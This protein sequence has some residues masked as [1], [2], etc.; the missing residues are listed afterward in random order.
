M[1]QFLTRAFV[2]A[3]AAMSAGLALAQGAPNVIDNNPVLPKGIVKVCKVGGPGIP[4]GTPFTFT[5]GSNTFTVPTGPTPGGTCVVGPS[6]PVGTHVTVAET[7]P[8][9]Y[10]VSSITV[11]PQVRQ[12]GTPNL[13]G[14]SV[15]VTVGSGV[16]EVT[17]TDKR[18][19]F[20][21]ICKNGDVQGNFNF[22][23]N[24]GGLGP[25]VVPA[26]AC[27]PAIEVAAGVVTIHELPT[28]GTGMSGCSTIPPGQQGACNLGAQTSTVTV[29]P[30]DV[31]T[32]T[33]AFVTNKKVADAVD[34]SLDKKFDKGPTVGTGAFTLTVKNEGLPIG[35]GTTIPAPTIKITDSVPAG[36]TFTGFGGTSGASWSCTPTFSVIGPNT[37]TCT[38]TGT[39]TIATGAVLPD[40]VFNATL[41]P[42]GS[43]IGIYRNCATVALLTAAGPVTESNTAN[44]Q[45]C[46]VNERINPIPCELVGN[47]PQPVAVCRQ[48]VLMVVD[49]SLSITPPGLNTVKTAIGKFLQPMQGKGGN[50][51][52]VSF[53]NAGIGT[54][55]S[56]LTQITTGGWVPVA[57]NWSTLAAPIVLGGTRTDWDDAL[58]RASALLAAP[59]TLPPLVLFITDG[60]PTAYIDNTSGLEIDATNTPV[61]AATEA[62]QWINAIRA[63]GSGSPI[64]A[65]G[66]GPVAPLG[67]L[68]AAFTGN[69]SGPGNINFE[70]SSV[71]KMG[72]VNDL[73]GVMATLGNQMC[74][75]LSLN[76]RVT[77]GPQFV[78]V[79][80]TGAT[81]LQVND[82]V[83]FR[84]ELTNNSS[85]T[86]VA[87]I[88][89]QDQV[90]SF[91]NPPAMVTAFSAGT[92]APPPTGNLIIWSIPM[93]AAR[94]TVTLDFTGKFVKTYP[95]PA[96]N[97]PTIETYPNYAQV[98]AAPPSYSAT[99]VGNMDPLNGPVTEVDES[100][101]TFS[102]YVYVDP[103][104][105]AGKPT[106]CYVQV[107]K[108][109]KNPESCTPSTGGTCQYTVNVILNSTNIPAGSTVT[110][111]DTFMVGTTPVSTPWP[112]SGPVLAAACPTGTPSA[113]PFT[114]NHGSLTSFSDVLSVT[115]P[116]GQNSQL[117]N[118]LTVTVASMANTT[119]PTV[120]ATACAP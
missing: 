87:G 29:D 18:T 80:P 96:V 43:E 76:K 69:S 44:N 37:L 5:A 13:A 32:M 74:G 81:S 88:V 85:T 115:I 42:A 63:A 107:Y 50:V 14:G 75:T 94:Q 27:S 9:G 15:N 7:I 106:W 78:H 108:V 66:F 112:A 51:N 17:F 26:G 25:Y 46:A 101:A 56:S 54:N 30:G 71:I 109:Q 6:F 52:I 118:C 97:V 23:V 55:N 70:T 48:D 57:G 62:V 31:S 103:C 68:D 2:F 49:A 105:V 86:P 21:E 114:C 98:T 99:V 113:V 82:T 47:C 33:I 89:V 110:V 73:P 102:E 83:P 28:A 16:T 59:L 38:Y 93:L 53:N 20:L 45:G 19:G 36:V 41:A 10:T 22:T 65:I 111:A 61:T 90:P 104:S 117:K 95:A 35:P 1:R 120:S 84:I 91:L 39:G 92:S 12:D 72:S 116:P 11:A 3:V 24:P 8:P 100:L 58:K 34:V 64:I 77:A 67:Y 60:E 40:L 119:P 79:V 4:V